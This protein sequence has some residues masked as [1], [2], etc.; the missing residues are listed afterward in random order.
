MH[1]TFGVNTF[2]GLDGHAQESGTSICFLTT[3]EDVW[4]P[5][6]LLG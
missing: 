5:P 1:S 2:V 4:C 6:D 3:N